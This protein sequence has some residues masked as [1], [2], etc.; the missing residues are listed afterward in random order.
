MRFDI[1]TLFPAF[2]DSPLRQSIM[3]RAALKGLIDVECHNIRDFALDKHKTTDDAPYGGGAGMLMKAP[4]VV[5]AIEAVKEKGRAGSKVVLL[6]P[7]GRPFDQAFA[8]ELSA[9]SGLI[10]VCGRY[11]GF[12]ERIREFVDIELSVGDYIL[13]GGEAAALTVIE[14]VGRLLPGVI[15]DESTLVE[16]FSESGLLEYPQY[17]RPEEFR[18][19]SVPKVLLSGNHEEIRKW[20][21]NKVLERTL[22]R[23]PELV[24]GRERE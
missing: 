13:C 1:L 24:K 23:R 5:D 7:Q 8:G 16:S 6:T 9:L 20:R 14:A 21:E 10:L 18:G 17:T 22:K 11:E 3:A 15:E 12:D 19:A 2:F 4:P